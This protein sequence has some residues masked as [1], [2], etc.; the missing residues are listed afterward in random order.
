M[1]LI[2]MAD[3]CTVCG[4]EINPADH[5]EKTGNKFCSTACFKK[6]EGEPKKDGDPN[7][8]EFC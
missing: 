6:F 1:Q 7:V 8:C 3:K 2:P 4:A 5:I